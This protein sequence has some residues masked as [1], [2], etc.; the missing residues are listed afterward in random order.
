MNIMSDITDL[1]SDRGMTQRQLA[2]SAR[3]DPAEV[4]R[5]LRGITCPT[6]R[7]L[8]RLLE[9]LGATL[10]LRAQKAKRSGSSRKSPR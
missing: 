7:T 3:I 10:E 1:L 4:S 2:E 6:L 8:E 9:P 5:Y